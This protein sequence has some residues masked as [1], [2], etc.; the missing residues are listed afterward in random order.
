MEKVIEFIKKNKL[1]KRG[2]VIGVGVSGGIDSMVLLSFLASHADELDIEVVAIH[3]D[4]GI[5][6]E[7]GKDAEFV[8]EKAKEL[9]VRLYKFK[10]DAPK[11]AKEKKVSLETGARIARYG[12][13]QSLLERDVI[14]KIALAHHQSDQAETILMHI[15]RGAGVF[16]A[17]GMEPI[18]DGV[19][20]RPLLD[21]GK[22]EIEEYALRHG[23]DHV[24]DATNQDTTY[25]RNFVRCVLL[26]EIEKRWPN[27][28]N[29]I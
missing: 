21:V 20:I 27:A 5:R 22:K 25:D 19:Y 7:S 17:K 24:E 3:V 18:R 26:K 9:G 11:I 2:E 6:A 1:I 10:I 14:D 12:V 4:H 8:A 29:S 28:T 16:G 15:F 13:F 23:I